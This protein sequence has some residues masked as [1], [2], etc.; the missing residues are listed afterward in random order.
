MNCAEV[1]C[2]EKSRNVGSAKSWQSRESHL[3][4]RTL[5]S[6]GRYDLNMMIFETVSTSAVIFT[7]CNA[8]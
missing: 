3:L 8:I 4:A 2:T 5:R 7:L 6:P 1:Q